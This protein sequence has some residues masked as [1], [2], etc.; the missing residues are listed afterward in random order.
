MI[1]SASLHRR[2]SFHQFF[3][4]YRNKLRELATYISVNGGLNITVAKR[5]LTSLSLYWPLLLLGISCFGYYYIHTWSHDYWG[6]LAVY[7]VQFFIFYQVY[8]LIIKVE[9]PD[10]FKYLLITG[11]LCRAILLP[12]TPILE[13]DFWRYMW[14]GRV[15]SNGVNPY[16]FAPNDS[17]LDG[18]STSYRSQIGWPELSTIYPPFA[19]LLFGL[20]H[21][22]FGDSVIGLKIIFLLFD[23]GIWWLLFCWLS[24]LGQNTKFSFLYLLNPLVLKEISN[25]AHLDSVVVFF[26]LLS[27]YLMSQKKMFRSA[28]ASLALATLTKLFPIVLI[29]LFLKFDRRWKLNILLFLLLILSFYLPFVEGKLLFGGTKAYASYWQFNASLY[30]VANFI[31]ESLNFPK[32]A[33]RL[34]IGALFFIF[35]VWQTTITR[36]Y[37]EIPLT[38]LNI[39]GALL[40]VSPVVDAWYV[41]WVL[42]FAILTSHTPWIVFSYLVVASYSWFYSSELALYFRLAE[43]GMFFGIYA[44][45]HLKK[46]RDKWGLND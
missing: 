16:D 13:D 15:I 21:I 45:W 44:W 37:S 10:S 42:P 12:S 43:Y 24:A 14:D 17:A 27:V 31:F 11:L 35:A 41:L 30:H 34:L 28:W 33:P 39:I 4:N 8:R 18:L 38:S 46:Q 6:L 9:S 20:A 32:Y 26:T 25:S 3:E 23:F 2:Q 1:F 29:P 19:Q 5:F 22:I 36:M 40:V 7:S